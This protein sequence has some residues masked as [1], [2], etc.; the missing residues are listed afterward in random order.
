MAS[1]LVEHRYLGLAPRCLGARSILVTAA[2]VPRAPDIELLEAIAAAQDIQVSLDTYLTWIRE[3][4]TAR[5]TGSKRN[6][7]NV[8]RV[9]DNQTGAADGCMEARTTAAPITEHADEVRCLTSVAH[10]GDG[11]VQSGPA[12]LAASL[13]QGSCWRLR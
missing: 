2:S 6:E 12:P 5:G 3:I 7:K 8:K 4:S 10:R 9:Q 13:R 1:S 11:V